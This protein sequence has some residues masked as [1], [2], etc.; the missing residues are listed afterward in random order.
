M[1]TVDCKIAG[2]SVEMVCT[3][4]FVLAREVKLIRPQAAVVE[5]QP[6]GPLRAG[7]AVTRMNSPVPPQAAA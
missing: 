7:P 1:E 2:Y 6:S 3:A 5:W 4:A